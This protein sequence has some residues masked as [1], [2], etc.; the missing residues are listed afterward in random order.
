MAAPVSVAA[1]QPVSRSTTCTRPASPSTPHSASLFAEPVRGRG[2][3]TPARGKPPTQRRNLPCIPR[4][5]IERL[6]VQPHC[7]LRRRIVGSDAVE[8]G[9]AALRTRRA[10][11]L[12]C[13][14]PSWKLPN[15]DTTPA[16]KP[17]LRPV[18][19]LRNSNHR[20]LPL[21]AGLRPRRLRRRL[22][23]ATATATAKAAKELRSPRVQGVSR[24]LP[25]CVCADLRC[26]CPCVSAF[27]SA[28]KGG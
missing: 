14:P 18:P 27:S 1:A 24:S 7:S 12:P 23:D 28:N 3:A 20:T 26:A 19:R 17:G 11:S 15:G 25:R 13:T 8:S 4:T 22:P 9:H 10:R 6:R 2:K 16:V 5:E 21:G